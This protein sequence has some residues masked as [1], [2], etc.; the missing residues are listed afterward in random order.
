MHPNQETTRT[1]WFHIRLSTC[2][3]L[4]GW[5]SWTIVNLPQVEAWRTISQAEAIHLNNRMTVQ[6]RRERL[7][8]GI[9]PNGSRSYGVLVR[10]RKS[11]AAFIPALLTLAA[12]IGWKTW[13]AASK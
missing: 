7:A 3:A 9:G 6:E 4:T 1:R 2:L 10:P 5:L 12:F 11:G 8:A 13:R